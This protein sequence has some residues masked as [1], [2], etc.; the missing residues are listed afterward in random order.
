M[1]FH[2]KNTLGKRKILQLLVKIIMT[3]TILAGILIILVKINF[4]FLYFTFKNETR[5]PVNISVETRHG[6]ILLPEMM[7][8]PFSSE[9]IKLSYEFFHFKASS[10]EGQ[11]ATK[12]YYGIYGNSFFFKT[13]Y[14]LEYDGEKINEIYARKID[15]GIFCIF[16]D[17]NE[18]V[19]R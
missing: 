15:C 5:F 1:N 14:L 8:T 18:I 12:G 17:D 3:L 19:P 16:Y 2:K 4:N 9:E 7:I 6:G 13:R 11:I 10:C